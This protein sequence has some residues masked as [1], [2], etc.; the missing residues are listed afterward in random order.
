MSFSP[1]TVIQE[2][3][4]IAEQH[5]EYFRLINF[6]QNVKRPS[7]FVRYY[8]INLDLSPND[9][10]TKATYDLYTKTR[11]QF[12]L[13]ELT[14]SF[15]VGAIQNS[16]NPVLEMKGI[17]IDSASTLTLY[18]IPNPRIGDLVT[19]YEP[20]KSDEVFKVSNIRLQLN[21]A[22]SS[23]PIRWFDVDLETAPITINDLDSLVKNKHYVYDLTQEKNLEYSEYK[24]QI[25][26][27]EELKKEL[28]KLQPYF[29][30]E[31]DLYVVDGQIYEDINLLIYYAKTE[32]EKRWRRLFEEIKVPYG[33]RYN[34]TI[35]KLGLDDLQLDGD[36]MVTTYDMETGTKMFMEPTLEAAELIETC[37]K[38]RELL[39]NGY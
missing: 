17:M 15:M 29:V 21:S 39:K 2:P 27:L 24:K 16:P 11:T 4:L 20:V 19:F 35:T 1:L 6:Y 9:D 37:N 5:A 18:T 22:Y 10:L 25:E 26:W 32:Y 14:P 34:Y 7:A 3:K 12:D 33:F 13:Y 28:K 31:K 38:I 36:Q 8:N 23:E 30:P